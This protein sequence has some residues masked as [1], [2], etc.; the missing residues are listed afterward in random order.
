MAA[1]GCFDRAYAVEDDSIYLIDPIEGGGVNVEDQHGDSHSAGLPQLD[2]ST[3]PSQIFWLFVSFGILYFIFSKKT[4]PD[5]SSVIEDRRSSIQNDLDMAA[6]LRDEA[7]KAHKAYGEAL[8]R[9][10][11][12]ATQLYLEQEQETKTHLADS[13]Q[14]FSE[15][16]TQEIKEAEKRLNE[17]KA[18]ALESI[19]M[20]A[21]DVASTIAECIIG[22]P[23]DIDQAKTVV[24]SIHKKK[25]A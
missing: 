22:V 8:E 20:V 1:N 10:R 17:A 21:A 12:K 11:E 24:R 25:A 13:L 19:N 3:Y 23:A 18:E 9:S 15:R 2:F 14:K 5:I 6:N 7:E 16:S 4:L